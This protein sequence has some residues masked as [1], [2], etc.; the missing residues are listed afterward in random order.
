MHDSHV[1]KGVAAIVGAVALAGCSLW[2]STDERQCHEDSDCVKAQLGNVCVQQVCIDNTGDTHGECTSS[3][4]SPSTSNSELGVN[5]TSCESD[6]NCGG[7][8][9]RC[10]N[11]TCVDD[12]TGNRWLCPPGDQTVKTSTVRYGF[13]VIDYLSR[14]PPKGVVA[15]ACR[16]SDVNCVEPVDMY[17]D[18]DET[19]HVLLTLPSGFLG[20]FEVRS[21]EMDTLLY[22]TKPIVKNTLNRDLPVLTPDTVNFTATFLGYDYVMDK[23]LVFLEALDCSGTPQGGVHFDSADGGDPFY[24]VD[25]Q[26]SKDAKMTVYDAVNNSANGGFVNVLTGFNEFSSSIGSDDAK[27]RLGAFNAQVRPRTVTFIDMYF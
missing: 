11:K 5:K 22:V 2:L 25:M 18:M 7:K 20:F 26:P 6:S 9:P 19:G 12:E 21:E 3:D 15:K 16:A 4:C 14:Q 1:V 10:L 24:L 23:G 17:T 27:I 13:H 8:T